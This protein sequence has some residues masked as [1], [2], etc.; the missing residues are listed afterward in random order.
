MKKEK[1]K[2]RRISVRG[3]RRRKGK[4]GG[5]S[6][7]V[8]SHSRRP[9]G[10]KFGLKPLRLR[11]KPPVLSKRDALKL[12]SKWDGVYEYRGYVVQV[13]WRGEKVFLDVYED[14]KARRPVERWLAAVED[15]R[16]VDAR[17]I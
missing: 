12:A 3:H 4:G 14:L 17:K 7:W 15:G 8:R 5:G 11:L 13:D 6:I 9:P 16:I 2:G 1:G 10:E